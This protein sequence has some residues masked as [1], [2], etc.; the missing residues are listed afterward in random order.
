MFEIFWTST[1]A[2][3]VRGSKR[4]AAIVADE[5]GLAKSHG[6]FA[7]AR[8]RRADPDFAWPK[9]FRAKIQHKVGKHKRTSLRR[10]HVVER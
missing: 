8:N 2:Q 4:P 7:Y 1:H 5:Q 6:T 3:D 10:R 9:D